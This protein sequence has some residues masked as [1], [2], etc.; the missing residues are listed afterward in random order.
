MSTHISI[1]QIMLLTKHRYLSLLLVILL[2]SLIPLANSCN[3]WKAS[4][5]PQ[6]PTADDEDIV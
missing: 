4:E 3:I 5:C 6:P 2:F 1:V